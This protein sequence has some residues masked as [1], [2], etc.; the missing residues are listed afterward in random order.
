MAVPA[1]Q[2]EQALTWVKGALSWMA[3]CHA[4]LPAVATGWEG[5]PWGA[6]AMAACWVL[7]AAPPDL[8]ASWIQGSSKR[9]L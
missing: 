2:Q 6:V 9:V 3:S 8:H 1:W 5:A 7:T 4:C